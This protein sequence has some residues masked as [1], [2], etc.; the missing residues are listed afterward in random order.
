[1]EDPLA[2]LHRET[3]RFAI[4]DVA[5]EDFDAERFEE[6]GLFG[7]PHQRR[8]LMTPTDELFDELAAK[9]PGRTGD[10]ESGHVSVTIHEGR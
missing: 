3:Q 7:S 6:R 8:H 5:T 9:K 2:P 1:V 10:E 4:G